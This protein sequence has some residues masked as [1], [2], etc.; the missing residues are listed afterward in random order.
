YAG[1]HAKEGF[2]LDKVSWEKYN[3]LIYS[4]AY[5]RDNTKRASYHAINGSDAS[6]LP[7]FVKK[8]HRHGVQAHL[9]VGG[10]TGSRWFSSSTAS[11]SNRTKFIDTL[12]RFARKHHL[13]GINFDWEAP[14]DPG[15]GCN[16]HSPNDTSNFLAYL[17]ELRA[18]PVGSGLTL[19]AAVGVNPFPDA[20]GNSSTNVSA[21]ADVFDY[22][23][24]MNYGVWGPWS[25]S[26]GPNVPLND[27]CMDDQ[28]GSAVSAVAVWMEAGMPAHKI[29]LGVAAYGHSYS[30]NHTSVFGSRKNL[31]LV[32]YPAFNASNPPA[33][34][35]WDDPGSV[36]ECGI[37]EDP[38]GDWDFWGLIDGG[39]LDKQGK[40]LDGI[41]YRYDECTHTPYVYNA[42]SEIMVSYDNVESFKM[43]GE[44]IKNNRLRGFA[45]WEAGGDYS[46][47][48]LDAIRLTS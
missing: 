18:D 8:A 28:E 30:V 36:D 15:I 14:N 17:Q 34:D 7:E 42:T 3:T 2:P 6:L 48:L 33:G 39:F 4:F 31:S 20:S 27:T 26:V 46:D 24:V 41:Y 11:A 21:F 10:W 38:S 16:T 5:V 47:I 43:K 35:K 37:Y 32:P 22:V 29:V 1:W 19:T 9:G 25:A 44:F 23:A 13:D 12:T 40:P 45:M